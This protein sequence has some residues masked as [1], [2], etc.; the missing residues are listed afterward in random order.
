MGKSTLADLV[1]GL[2]VPDK[3]KIIIDKT[4]LKSNN[5]I[6]WRNKFSYVPQKVFL[7]DE[8]IKNNIILGDKEKNNIKND[9]L[10]Q[11]LKFSQ[12]ETFV[13]SKRLKLD[14]LITGNGMKLS[15]GQRQR[16]GI[17]RCLYYNKEIIIFDEATAG[18]DKITE[19]NLLN[20]CQLSNKTII[21]ISHNKSIINNCDDFIDLDEQ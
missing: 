4:T 9:N 19:N 5:I 14:F 8:T 3:G 6:S 12:L 2:I 13:N 10:K 11:S 18:L 1:S 16:I 21:I 20:N 15:G 17:A 7:F